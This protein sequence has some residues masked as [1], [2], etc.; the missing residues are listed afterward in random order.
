MLYLNR[1]LLGA[2]LCLSLTGTLH[3]QGEVAILQDPAA[4]PA[5]DPVLVPE[6]KIPV[7]PIV[8]PETPLAGMPV[9]PQ[10]RVVIDTCD[11]D[12]CWDAHALQRT[13][14][15]VTALEKR[16]TRTKILNDVYIKPDQDKENEQIRQMWKE[17]FWGRDVWAPYYQAKEIEDWVKERVSFRVFK[18]K[19]KPKFDKDGFV[20]VC[21]NR[22]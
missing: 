11:D 22:F 6:H 18:M 4:P 14:R 7:E 8:P 13:F 9:S 1:P 2:I 5:A 21:K 12:T 3:A 15:E 19:C 17:F 10:P 20:Y 16:A